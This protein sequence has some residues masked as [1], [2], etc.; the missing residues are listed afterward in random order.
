ML[1]RSEMEDFLD[2]Q[3]SFLFTVASIRLSG[4][5]IFKLRQTPDRALGQHAQQLPILPKPAIGIFQPGTLAVLA[6]AHSL[7]RPV[8]GA[9]SKR[10]LSVGGSPHVAFSALK[11]THL[12]V[13]F[14]RYPGPPLQPQPLHG[15]RSGHRAEA[16]KARAGRQAMTSVKR[17][18]LLKCTMAASPRRNTV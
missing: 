17:P 1:F 11:P 3:K 5:A 16:G 15:G 14:I 9:F 4:R 6:K 10:H 18:G 13:A 12:P 2:F 8:P 7:F